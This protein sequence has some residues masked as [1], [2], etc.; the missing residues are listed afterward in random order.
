MINIHKDFKKMFYK[1]NLMPAGLT[2]SLGAEVVELLA[3][4]GSVQFPP[5]SGMGWG[6]LSAGI[7]GRECGVWVFY[8]PRLL[9]A[10]SCGPIRIFSYII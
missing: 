8:G 9:G 3:W 5:G 4:L 10:F 7:A 2:S 1:L 6:F